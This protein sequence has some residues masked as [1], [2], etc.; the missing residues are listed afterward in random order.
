[1]FVVDYSQVWHVLEILEG[2]PAESAG[3]VPFGDYILGYSGG[4]LHKESDFY[5]L[6][7]E[8]VDKP[9]RL[10]VYNADFDVTREVVIVPNRA[11]SSSSS[12]SSSTLNGETLGAVGGGGLLGCGVGYG[13][14]H[15][16]PKPQSQHQ[17]QQQQLQKGQAAGSSTTTNGKHDETASAPPPPKRMTAS[18]ATTSS[19]SSSRPSPAVANNIASPTPVRSTNYPNHQG[20]AMQG[21]PQRGGVGTAAA[22]LGIGN[23]PG[24]SS[25]AV[26]TAP[27]RS[28][29]RSS[30]PRPSFAESIEEEEEESLH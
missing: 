19:G 23:Y 9:L 17:Q 14:L 29:S 16:I 13:V 28:P 30:S 2:S 1:M 8:H 26:L 25:T 4:V 18:V 7:E 12:S 24:A 22:A 21:S 15:R 3:L 27:P 10:F 11:W 5:K 20:L 6:I